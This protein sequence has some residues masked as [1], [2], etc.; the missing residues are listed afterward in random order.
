[1]LVPGRVNDSKPERYTYVHRVSFDD[2]LQ[3]GNAREFIYMCFGRMQTGIAYMADGRNKR[4]GVMNKPSSSTPTGME[5]M[6]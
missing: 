1:M 6:G 3:S 4:I 2:H 5:I